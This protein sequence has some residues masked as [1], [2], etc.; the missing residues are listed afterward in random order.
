LQI[1]RLSLHSALCLGGVLPNVFFGIF[2]GGGEGGAAS[3]GGRPDLPE[4][5]GSVLPD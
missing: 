4:S 1:L 5:L 2:E 3:T